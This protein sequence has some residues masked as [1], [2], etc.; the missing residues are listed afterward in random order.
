MLVGTRG[1]LQAGLRC[2]GVTE[3]ALPDQARL[4]L[5]DLRRWSRVLQ[6]GMAAEMLLE[7]PAQGG[8]DDRALL[9]RIWGVSGQ[10]VETAQREQRRARREVE[11]LLRSKRSEIEAIA[12]RLMDGR[13]PEAA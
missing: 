4:S 7:G 2:N 6:A 9:G 13:S 12:D 1:C 11:Q 5:E 3:F 8:E 10:D